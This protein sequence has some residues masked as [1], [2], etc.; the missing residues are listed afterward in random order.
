MK[1]K[2]L[3]F[4]LIWLDFLLHVVQ[5]QNTKTHQATQ[6]ETREFIQGNFDTNDTKLLMKQWSMYCKRWIYYHNAVSDL[7]V[8]M[9]KQELDR[10]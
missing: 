6:L 1:I 7:G 4:T 8:L 10:T 5:Y 3:I 9:A 2:F